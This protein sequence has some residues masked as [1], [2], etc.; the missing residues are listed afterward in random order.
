MVLDWHREWHSLEVQKSIFDGKAALECPYCK[1]GIAYVQFLLLGVAVSECPV[2]K[3][4]I[5]KAA[6]WAQICDGKVLREYLRTPPGLPFGDSW[7][8]AEIQA[9]DTK[10]AA[11]RE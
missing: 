3:R 11:T 7:S 4:D 5:L 9:A 2:A 6:E 8:N 1:S 10:A